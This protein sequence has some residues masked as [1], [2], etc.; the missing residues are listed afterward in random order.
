MPRKGNISQLIGH[1]AAEE[2]AADH[3]E[4]LQ[5]FEKEL[6]DSKSTEEMKVHEDGQA[7]KV[8]VG[9]RANLMT[10]DEVLHLFMP[11]MEACAKWTLHQDIIGVEDKT[12]WILVLREY[13]AVYS[14]FM[15]SENDLEIWKARLESSVQAIEYMKT[16]SASPEPGQVV[17]VIIDLC[18]NKDLKAG[19]VITLKL[20]Y[21]KLNDHPAV[22][23]KTVETRGESKETFR[24][25]TFYAKTND[26][27]IKHE[28]EQPVIAGDSIR[29]RVPRLVS[30]P[31]RGI[32]RQDSYK[33][34]V[35]CEA[36]AG[37]SMV[38]A[39]A[40]ALVDVPKK[41]SH[42]QLHKRFKAGMIAEGVV[43]GEGEA[44]GPEGRRLKAEHVAQIEAK[45]GTKIDIDTG[46]PP[47]LEMRDSA[48]QIETMGT[49]RRGKVGGWSRLKTQ[50]EEA[51]IQREPWATCLYDDEFLSMGAPELDDG[52]PRHRT[53]HVHNFDSGLGANQIMYMPTAKSA[54]LCEHLA[55]GV[56]Y[57]YNHAVVSILETEGRYRIIAQKD[58][59]EREV[60]AQNQGT[61]ADVY[62]VK[63]AGSSRGHT[64]G[65]GYSEAQYTDRDDSA[66]ERSKSPPRLST[67]I[68]KRRLRSM[69]DFDIV[70][71]CT[72][73]AVAA[74]LTAQIAP[75]MSAACRNANLEPCWVAYVRIEPV[76]ALANDA[77][78]ILQD[79]EK[80]LIWATRETSRE[81][82]ASKGLKKFDD[83]R[84]MNML[85]KGGR[86][87]T[88]VADSRAREDSWVLH[89]SATWTQN[90]ITT[91]PE[92][93][94]EI[95]AEHFVKLLN[96]DYEMDI[97]DSYAY[98]WKEGKYNDFGPYVD[99]ALPE[100]KS[101]EANF[102]KAD[103]NGGW[104]RTGIDGALF[105][106]AKGV[107][108]A[109]DWLVEGTVEGA[110]LSG[111]ALA[112]RLIEAHASYVPADFSLAPNK[113]MTDAGVDHSD[114]WGYGDWPELDVD[115]N[116]QQFRWNGR[117]VTK[118]ATRL[119][120]QPP[121]PFAGVPLGRPLTR[122]VC[123]DPD[124]NFHNWIEGKGIL[125]DSR[126]PSTH[127]GEGY[128]PIDREGRRI[129]P[130]D[131]FDFLDVQS[132]PTTQVHMDDAG[133]P[134][135]N[136]G[137]APPSPKTGA[138]APPLRPLTRGLLKSSRS[139][140]ASPTVRNLSVKFVRE[141]ELVLSRTQ[142]MGASY[143]RLDL[144]QSSPGK[145]AGIPGAIAAMAQRQ[146]AFKIKPRK[147]RDTSP[148]RTAESHGMSK[149]FVWVLCNYRLTKL[150]SDCRDCLRR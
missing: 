131:H 72:P 50:I 75:Q 39:M 49:A 115:A 76:L 35:R 113:N 126:P 90:N 62:R 9:A 14:A 64:A 4:V 88:A 67:A 47:N 91:P 54:N 22:R 65:S 33:F 104:G 119:M 139:N 26:L 148:A 69:G 110:F 84:A 56:K 114:R 120:F 77:F 83:F 106:A 109:G 41:P 89:A 68:A 103:L 25:A 136:Q 132:R 81:E 70:L 60:T 61:G 12:E 92:D 97:V 141:D 80:I 43:G 52:L 24:S 149:A 134:H 19:D 145:D 15:K 82:K 1:D 8:L 37:S 102:L 133:Y 79:P 85:L 124:A 23:K 45:I 128:M 53:A 118:R 34:N 135:S 11:D 117:P 125:P 48:Q 13:A 137:R 123:E 142:K 28:H 107:G 143:D 3:R 121:N 71:V 116:H 32:S 150:T 21:F 5:G 40:S 127:Y 58:Q 17:D 74:T 42:I 147:S 86:P 18:Y 98:L 140:I 7:A 2:I 146:G 31:K 129:M 95:L 6:G 10:Y 38:H 16:H 99:S 101:I 111:A 36:A 96:L 66:H 27:V 51:G 87:S 122:N 144:E 59:E 30:V 57:V 130:S 29:L 108:V 20:P 46:S 44:I 78:A 73:P 93:V 112:Q 105:D 100:A 94:A 63:T 138:P 55:P